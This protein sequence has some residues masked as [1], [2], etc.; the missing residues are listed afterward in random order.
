VADALDHEIPGAET[1]FVG[2]SEFFDGREMLM[3]H[4]AFR[5]E[6]A[7]APGLVRRVDDGDTLRVYCQHAQLI[8]GTP[9]PPR[10]SEVHA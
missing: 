5:S 8:H 10:S 4:R 7:L 1:S 3:V 6:F 2:H 9:K